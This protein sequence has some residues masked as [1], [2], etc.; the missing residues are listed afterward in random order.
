MIISLVEHHLGTC[1]RFGRLFDDSSRRQV[2][3]ESIVGAMPSSSDMTVDRAVQ[4]VKIVI[5]VQRSRIS[6][7]N[8]CQYAMLASLLIF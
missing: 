3:I 4:K 2:Y 7:Q 1:I 6:K 8:G 5:L